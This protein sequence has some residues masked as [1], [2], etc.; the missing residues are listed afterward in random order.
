MTEIQ[1]NEV[2]RDLVLMACMASQKHYPKA[3]E[4]MKRT[5]VTLGITTELEFQF[6]HYLAR[7]E[8]RAAEQ[9]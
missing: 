1:R 3:V 5:A 6:N 7:A 2:A 4:A 8:L 9:N